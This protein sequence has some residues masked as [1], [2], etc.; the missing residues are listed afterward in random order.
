VKI[1]KLHSKNPHRLDTYTKHLG[2]RFM[3]WL[4]GGKD[5]QFM[6]CKSTSELMKNSR[7]STTS[8]KAEFDK[9]I[10]VKVPV[11]ATK[12]GSITARG[13]K[14]GFSVQ[15]GELRDGD[16][17]LAGVHINFGGRTVERVTSSM[18][19]QRIPTKYFAR[20][21]LGDAWK[22]TLNYNKTVIMEYAKDPLLVEVANLT[23]DLIDKLVG[24]D[25]QKMFEKLSLE[26]SNMMSPEL[27]SILKKALDGESEATEEGAFKDE[28]EVSGVDDGDGPDPDPDPNP[29]EPK[30]VGRK[31][32]KDKKASGLFQFKMV[33]VN[34]DEGQAIKAVTTFSGNTAECE[35]TLNTKFGVINKAVMLNPGN[36]PATFI[37]CV[38]ALSEELAANDKICTKLL[39]TKFI[40]EA[41]TTAQRH[42]MFTVIFNKLMSLSVT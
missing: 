2:M 42:E 17:S 25:Q 27:G 13:M 30:G 5:I 32:G 14:M 11:R 19:E 12:I 23:K 7:L 29:V 1:Q 21:D 38:T 9:L 20:V 15:Y 10:S 16:S 26:I 6:K 40:G 41:T 3:P 8:I 24:D 4:E 31:D 22:E 37:L 36:A 39:G 34:E 28:V 33:V 35:V 18:G